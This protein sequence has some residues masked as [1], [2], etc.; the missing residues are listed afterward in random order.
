MKLGA[1]LANDDIAGQHS[2]A[3][4]LLDAQTPARG[5]AAITGTAA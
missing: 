5:I 2:L 1:A 4:G 3:A